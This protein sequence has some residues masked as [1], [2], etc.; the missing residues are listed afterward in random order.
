MS[1]PVLGTVRSTIAAGAVGALL[2]SGVPAAAQPAP[3]H[4]SAPAAERASAVRIGTFNINAGLPLDRWRQAVQ[5]FSALVDIGGIQEAAGKDKAAALRSMPGIGSYVSQRFLQEPVF[6]NQDAFRLVKGR[7]PK[8]AAGRKVESKTGPGLVHQAATLAT[9]AR[10][11]SRTSGETISVVNV[12]LLSGSVNAGKPLPGVPRRVGMYT[13]QVRNLGK[14]VK[15]EKKWSGGP[16]WVVGDF[17]VNYGRDKVVR[18]KRFAFSTL[19]RRDLVASWEARKGQLQPGHGSGSRS[20]AYLDV[21]WSTRKA[22]SVDV[23]RDEQFRVS[24]HFPVVSAYRAP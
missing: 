13:D 7:S 16:V 9:V 17:N 12:H 5:D 22:R 15:K 8:I 6:W 10:L 1:T 14:V 3:E 24:D 18:K 20:G 23:R 19:R 11:R 2:L 4:R 21:I